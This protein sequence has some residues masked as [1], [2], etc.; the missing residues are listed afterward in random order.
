MSEAAQ[1][2]QQPK[3]VRYKFW[4]LTNL[5]KQD[6]KICSNLDPIYKSTWEEYIALLDPTAQKWL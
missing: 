4:E 6:L 3:L 1:N 5:H 2:S